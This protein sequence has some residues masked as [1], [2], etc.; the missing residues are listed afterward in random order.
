MRA[1]FTYGPNLVLSLC[2]FCFALPACTAGD[3]EGN[4]PERRPNIVVIMADDLG[5][6][7]LGSYGGEIQTPRID[8]L[9][10]NGI[11]FTQFYNAGRCVPSR[12]S[13]L[14]GLYAHKTGL[15]YMTAQDYGKP[16]YRGD[17]NFQSVTIAEAL[18]EAGYASYMAG[19]WHVNLDFS[20]DGLKHNWPLQ[21]GFDRFFGT[22]IAAGSYW[23]PMTLVEGNEY[24]EPGEDFYYTEAITEKAIEFINAHD[25]DS[26][27][28]L[29]VAYTAPHWPLHAREEAIA[30]HR[31]RFAKGWDRLRE[32]RHKRMIDAGIVDE[33]WAL[34]ERDEANLPW[35]EAD[36]REWEQTRMEAYAGTI[37]HLDEGVGELVDALERLGE[38]E[39][40]IIFFLS[41]N[42]GDKTEHID[43][44][45]GNSGKPWSVMAYVPLYTRSGEL[46]LA[47]D[48]PDVALGPETTYGGYGLK[49]ANLSNTPFRKF[50]SYAHEGGIASPLIVHWPA[51]IEAK[52][53]LRRQPAHIIDIMATSLELA[54]ADYP[55]D[56]LGRKI[57]SLDGRSMMPVIERD[58]RIR[59]ALFWEHEGN[60][61]VRVGDWKLVALRGIEEWAL[62]DLASDRTETRDLSSKFP[63]KVRELKA[64]YEEWAAESQVIPW[65]EMSI[66]IIAG[67]SSPL[68]RPREEADEA[69]RQVQ[70]DLERL[71]SLSN[72]RSETEDGR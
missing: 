12:A 15:G 40:T 22:L 53:E 56:Y 69:F 58:D 70:A 25:S 10:A 45:I 2:L 67:K 68:A 11:R 41:D 35:Q 8:E 7:D 64:T 33:S 26:P 20:P 13:L 61:A 59:D 3:T 65:D 49:W 72:E 27:F 19:K 62:Y 57:R 34:P 39:N 29:Y 6:S 14:T 21:R 38:L 23:D 9:A 60:R 46:V 54:E 51:G 4:A 16:G 28:F 71:R 31:G 36:D 32:E 42:G 24:T 17:L 43:G 66:N 5:Y 18:G 50:K 63:G 44:L 37:V 48:F 55:A 1:P 47:G 52:N 30:N